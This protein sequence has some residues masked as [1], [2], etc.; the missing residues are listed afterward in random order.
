MATGERRELRKKA[1]GLAFFACLCYA[2]GHGRRLP[3][4]QP[5]HHRPP[6]RV[7]PPVDRAAPGGHPA[8]AFAAA[9]RGVAVEADQRGAA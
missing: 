3:L 4:P 1:R 9:V 7:R 8:A 5:S 6:G 2:P